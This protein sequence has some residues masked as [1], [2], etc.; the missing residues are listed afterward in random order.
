MQQ[1]LGMKTIMWKLEKAYD[2]NEFGWVLNNL[3]SKYIKTK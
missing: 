2:F 3:F 1:R